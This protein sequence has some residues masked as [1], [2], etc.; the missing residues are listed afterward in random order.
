MYMNNK[1]KLSLFLFSMLV[2]FLGVQVAIFAQERTVTIRLQ[3]IGTAADNAIHFVPWA[4]YVEKAS[5]GRI[6]VQLHSSCELVPDENM[7]P[8]LKAGTLDAIIYHAQCNPSLTD[9]GIIETSLVFGL[10]NQNEQMCFF[11][12]RGYEELVREDYANYGVHYIGPT[13]FDPSITLIT[14][15]PVEK[16]SDLKGL[17]ISSFESMIKPFIVF[18]SVQINIPADELYL[19]GKTGVVDGL[20]W[21]GVP[22]YYYNSWHEV[23]PYLLD[24]S[25]GN[26]CMNLIFNNNVWNSLPED[27]QAIFELSLS[28][29]TEHSQ[30]LYYNDESKYRT[31]FISSK[32]SKEERDQ[33]IE[34]AIQYWDELATKNERLKTAIQMY[35]DYNKELNETGWNR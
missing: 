11:K 28:W 21:G 17:K 9:L 14:T 27:I 15:K 26:F 25:L 29:M 31:E 19:A 4:N 7:L 24:E 32:F 16:I 2:F 33:M 3:H 5:N 6:K 18:G 10:R 23:Y 12:H 13:L 35:K 8:A 30:N 1:I 22:C 20:V 34:V